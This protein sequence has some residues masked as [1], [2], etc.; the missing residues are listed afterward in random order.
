MATVQVLAEAIATLLDLGPGDTTID[1][2]GTTFIDAA[3]LN[4]LVEYSTQVGARGAKMTVVGA[5][6]RVRRVF[7]LV[8]LGDLLEG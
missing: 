8:N 1:I 5:T 3:G 4:C 6:P 7:D 2:S